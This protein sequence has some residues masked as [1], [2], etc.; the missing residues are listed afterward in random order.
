MA[1]E[2]GRSAGSDMTFT[3]AVIPPAADTLAATDIAA[4]SAKLHGNLTSLGTAGIVNVC[5]EYGTTAGYGAT[6]PVKTLMGA[7]LFADNLSGLTPATTY[8]F[9]ARA[10][11]GIHGTAYGIDLTF[12]TAESGTLPPV[13]ETLAAASISATEATLKGNLISK[14]SSSAVNVYFDY[15]LN[16]N[17]GISSNVL[18]I[19]ESGAFNLTIKGLTP[20]TVYHFRAEA[21]GGINGSSTGSDFS[22]TTTTEPPVVN[23]LATSSISATSATL[24]GELIYPGTAGTVNVYFEYGTST[25][26]DN[27]TPDQSLFA[28]GHFAANIS[29]LTPGTEY[30]FRARADGGKHGNAAGP[31]MTFTTADNGSLPPAI[32]T[33]IATSISANSAVLNGNLTSLGTAGT[34]NVYFEY[35]TSTGY[36]NITP[37]KPT[38]AKGPVKIS[39]KGLTAQTLYHFRVVADGGG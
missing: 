11:G 8:H 19:T 7:G 14:G 4:S 3:T 23:T 27:F 34:V 36:D 18:Q 2:N 30:H 16:L 37:V 31:D 6:T 28:A 9:R 1:G 17:Y 25:N 24:N 10:D 38:T 13:V 22:F 12:T 20:D 26:Y 15:G 39:I 33:T 35:G 5:F 29:G 21:D 32:N